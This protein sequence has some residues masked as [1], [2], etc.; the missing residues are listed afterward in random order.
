MLPP[1]DTP[2]GAVADPAVDPAVERAS[3]ASRFRDRTDGANHKHLLTG[4]TVLVACAAV[5]GVCGL[6]FSLVV[7]QW[8][9]KSQ[10]GNASA[11][12][13]SVLFVV[14]LAGLGLPVALARYSTDRSIDA[15]VVFAWGVVCTAVASVVTS[16][17]YL[18]VVNPKAARVLWDWHPVLG[19]ALFAAIVMGSAFSLIVDVRCMTL[20]RWN[21]VLIRVVL[22]S[23]VK[24]AVLPLAHHSANRSLLLFV[25]LSAPVAVSGFA[26]VA[27]VNRLTGGRHRLSPKPP[28]ARAATRYS[29][30]NYLSTLAYQAPYFA[31]PVIV[32]V[33]VAASVNSSFYVAWGIVAIAFYVP[34]AI[35]QALL[36]EGGKDG[37]H[38]QAQ[39]RTALIL[40]IGIMAA[41]TA[42]SFV[43]RGVVIAAY[44]DDYRDAA[45]ILPTM[46]AAGIP[47]AV[48]SLLLTEARVMHRHVATVTITATLTLAIIIPALI[49]VPG[50][51]A[52][53][54]LVGAANSWFL[55]NVAAALVAIG[56]TAIGR[57]R[58]DPAQAA[59]AE[60]DPLVTAST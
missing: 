22:V 23:V 4:S 3:L 60:L 35:G 50:H 57:H 11:L 31:L 24:L 45:H 1:S 12:Y 52:G 47:W 55:G 34:S 2:A 9:H 14:Y 28:T 32:L 36:A 37:A 5:Q 44:G 49:L 56:V 16:G 21:L 39:V 29:L 17:L 33:H 27:F 58:A 19:F 6:A 41:G 43:G 8:H 46:M 10:F 18:G 20:R 30:V 15:H 40:A 42:L 26:G 59:T 51:A 25:F 54:G 38:V 13:T 48:T 7:A 53:H